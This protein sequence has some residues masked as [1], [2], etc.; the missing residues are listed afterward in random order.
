MHNLIKSGLFYC[1]SNSCLDCTV[2]KI[3]E[4]LFKKILEDC[5]ICLNSNN[6]YKLWKCV[7]RG[8]WEG[9]TFSIKYLLQWQFFKEFKLK[10]P[11]LIKKKK[12]N[13]PYLW[14]DLQLLC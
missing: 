11:L 8:G 6:L 3:I 14:L 10:P 5:R 13:P 4:G 1:N 7:F 2:P 9:N 12:P